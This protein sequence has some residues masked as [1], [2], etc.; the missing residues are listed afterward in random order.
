MV[1]I[2]RDDNCPACNPDDP[3][4]ECECGDSRDQHE[5]SVG[6][7]L[8]CRG[9]GRDWGDEQH[10]PCQKFVLYEVDDEA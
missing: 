5:D 6:K 3:W 1:L 9:G 7:C 10:G 2:V 4:A 8:A